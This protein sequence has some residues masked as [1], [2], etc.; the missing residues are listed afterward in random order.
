[1]RSMMRLRSSSASTPI[2]CH[3]AKPVGVSVSMAGQRTELHATGRG[4]RQS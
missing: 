1:V 3:M 4:S 2:F